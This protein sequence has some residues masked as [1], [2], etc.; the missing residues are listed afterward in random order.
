MIGFLRGHRGFDSQF[1]GID[2]SRNTLDVSVGKISFLVANNSAGFS[3][4][5]GQLSQFSV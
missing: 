4:L 1:V 5:C 3:E 2:V